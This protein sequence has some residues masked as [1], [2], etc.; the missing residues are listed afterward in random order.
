MFSICEEFHGFMEKRDYANI[1]TFEFYFKNFYYTRL[2][3]RS[4]L[5][6][7]TIFRTR[8]QSAENNS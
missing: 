5:N 4:L 8:M 7:C 6:R 2:A 3:F 1:L